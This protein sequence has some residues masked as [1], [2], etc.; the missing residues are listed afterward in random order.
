MMWCAPTRPTPIPKTHGKLGQFL[1]PQPHVPDDPVGV[2][3]KRL[4]VYGRLV[5]VDVILIDGPGEMTSERK[6]RE[7]ESPSAR[8]A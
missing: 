4:R 8:F 5:E 7:S 2:G 6:M 3:N 1:A